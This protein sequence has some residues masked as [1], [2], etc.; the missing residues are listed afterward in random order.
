MH[1]F[2]TEA[3]PRVSSPS[4]KQKN[5]E[6]LSDNE[7]ASSTSS[8]NPDPPDMK[9]GRSQK[10][11]WDSATQHKESSSLRHVQYPTDFCGQ[12]SA[13][14]D[15]H[16]QHIHAQVHEHA[17]N[18]SQ[19]YENSHRRGRHNRLQGSMTRRSSYSG[20]RGFRGDDRRGGGSNGSRGSGGSQHHSHTSR[21][22]Y[23]TTASTSA[24]RQPLPTTERAGAVLSQPDNHYHQHNQ[25]SQH[26]RR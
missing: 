1:I 13:G 15:T 5:E 6:A 17:R 18:H 26:H 16:Y 21:N 11:R 22:G 23:R 12:S 10:T 7:T 19:Q 2:F 4:E 9:Q 3:T 14:N 24:H 8:P 20:G 25:H